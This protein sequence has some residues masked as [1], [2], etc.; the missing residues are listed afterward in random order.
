[1]NHVKNRDDHGAG[2]DSGR[3]LDFRQE[4]DPGQYFKF[5]SEQESIVRSVE[6]CLLQL[7]AS[8]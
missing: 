7:T 3:N 2:V 1:V 8:P 5:E 6:E 4:Q